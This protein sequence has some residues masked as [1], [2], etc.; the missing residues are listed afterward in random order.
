[1]IRLGCRAALAL[2]PSGL[3]LAAFAAD[4]RADP[5]GTS[6][7]QRDVVEVS[8][9]KGIHIGLVDI[10]NRLGDVRIEGNDRDSISIMAVKRAPDQET[11]E[12]LKVLLVPD[13]NGSISITT[14]LKAGQ[15]SRP[16]RAGSVRIDLVVLA[17]RQARV[18][19]QVW[20]R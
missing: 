16:I 9:T 17:P 13:P 15:E 4:V 20:R 1:M 2:M 7:V 12:R 14:A 11:M 10:D 6:L 18:R 19:A 5:S 8:P 3:L